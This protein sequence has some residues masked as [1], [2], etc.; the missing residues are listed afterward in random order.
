MNQRVKTLW[1]EALRSGEFQQDIGQLCRVG[2]DGVK[3]YC[4]LGVL[5][6]LA[7]REGVIESFQDSDGGLDLKVMQWAEL[8]DTLPLA[9]K[10]GLHAMNDN[11]K[12]FNYIADQIEKYL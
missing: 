3:R 6:E 12:D 10:V 7:L 9:G 2:A 4:C 1:I 11:D 5:E 8:T